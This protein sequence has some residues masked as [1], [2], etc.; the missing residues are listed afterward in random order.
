MILSIRIWKHKMIM[1][2][3]PG[4]YK[5][6][7][8]SVVYFIMKFYPIFFFSSP[9]PDE[10]QVVSF[11]ELLIQ[12]V[13]EREVLWDT[14][15]P[16]VVRSKNARD[17]AWV[18]I[19]EFFKGDLLKIIIINLLFYL[20]TCYSRTILSRIITEKVEKLKRYFHKS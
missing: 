4:E 20:C 12:A 8:Y 17:Q 6:H 14:S 19:Q 3:L 7:T 9:N 13:H 5:G 16:I 18:E 2:D 1:M 15:L 11:E 10:S